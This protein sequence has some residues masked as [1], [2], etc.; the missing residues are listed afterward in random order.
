MSL[1]GFLCWVEESAESLREKVGVI[2]HTR[3]RKARGDSL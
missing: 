2:V 1:L 3:S